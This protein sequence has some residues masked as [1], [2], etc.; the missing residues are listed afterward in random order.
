MSNLSSI[1]FCDTV[2]DAETI[3]LT[4]KS[5][6]K[7]IVQLDSG[8]FKRDAGC[9]TFLNDEPY[10]SYENNADELAEEEQAI[11]AAEDFYA[12][13]DKAYTEASQAL[14]DSGIAM[15]KLL[16]LYKT[17]RIPMVS[18]LGFMDGIKSTAQAKT[19]QGIKHEQ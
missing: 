7:W 1:K 16:D 18:F 10:I 11:S 13:Q 14:R 12:R 15:S 2:D 19:I 3:S 4:F 17:G 9:F 6:N 8:K 5:G